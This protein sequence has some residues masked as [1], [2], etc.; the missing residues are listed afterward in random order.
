MSKSRI[1]D[2]LATGTGLNTAV[3]KEPVDN[4]F[5]SNGDTPARGDEVRIAG[6]GAFVTRNRAAR[7]ARNPQRA[8]LLTIPAIK[9]PSF[10]A[11]KTLRDMANDE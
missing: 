10:K 1:A 9:T 8:E 6:S 2:R 11:G 3:V 5:R 4:L 7:T